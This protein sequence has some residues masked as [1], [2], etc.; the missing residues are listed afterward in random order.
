MS[1]KSCKLLK[2]KY[3][4][5]RPGITRIKIPK[6]SKMQKRGDYKDLLSSF[7][8][9]APVGVRAGILKDSFSF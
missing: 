5:S 9:T 1:I 6:Y 2:I 7:N 3:A 4:F 8:T